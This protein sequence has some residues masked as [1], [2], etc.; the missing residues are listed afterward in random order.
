MSFYCYIKKSIIDTLNVILPFSEDRTSDRLNL[1]DH[2]EKMA[3]RKAFNIIRAV[4]IVG[5]AYGAVRGIVYAAAGDKDEAYHSVI[6]DLADLNPLRIPRN[7]AHGIA[8]VTNDLEKG[9]WIGKRPIA[10][11]LVG[12]N[13]SP[14]VDGYHWC[15]QINGIIY[16]LRANTDCEVTIIIRSKTE[17]KAQYESDCKVYSWYLLQ[18]DLPDFDPEVLKAFAKSFEERKFQLILPV[19]GK[20]NCQSFSTRMFAAAANISIIKARS[21]IVLVIPNFLF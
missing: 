6:L 11:Q 16:Q 10:R 7:L 8:S 21:I 15:I 3:E 19:G 14:G 18:R 5:H 9:V 13:I 4:P 20:L 2:I 17:H 1:V 12:L